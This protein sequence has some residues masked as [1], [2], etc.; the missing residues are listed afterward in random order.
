MLS[1]LPSPGTVGN[2]S[3]HVLVA[4]LESPFSIYNGIFGTANQISTFDHQALNQ[5]YKGKN[6]AKV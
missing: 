6:S 2:I 3:L 4:Q 5:V 1:L